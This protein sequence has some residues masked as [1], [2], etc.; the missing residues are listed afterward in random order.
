MI[1]STQG[2]NTYLIVT[3]VIGR[4]LCSD[5]PM[6][7]P[8]HPAAARYVGPC[9]KKNMMQITHDHRRQ[10]DTLYQARC[11]FPALREVTSCAGCC[12]IDPD[13]DNCRLLHQLHQHWQQA[14]PEAGPAYWSVRSWTMLIWQ[15]IYLTVFAVQHH[16]HLPNVFAMQQQLQH[17]IVA[18]FHLTQRSMVTTDEPTLIRHGAL[19]LRQ[20]CHQ[21]LLQ[22]A[23]ICP[24]RP[25]LAWRLAA[26]TVL[27][28]LCQL[29]KYDHHYSNQH[30]LD[31]AQ[32]WLHAMELEHHSALMRVPLANDTETL[33]LQRK[34]CCF[35]YLRCCGQVCTTCPRQSLAERRLRIE[36]E[37]TQHA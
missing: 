26:D 18:G 15:P 34:A 21:F 2:R 16:R 9:C 4:M 29:Q 13:T 32:D 22:L 10:Q 3:T 27:S 14:H 6:T 11:F 23:G 5:R 20:L 17:G 12:F 25:R 33:A 28:A 35:D 31:L 36:Q 8:S 1:W 30:I 24:L 7:C 19:R 37:L